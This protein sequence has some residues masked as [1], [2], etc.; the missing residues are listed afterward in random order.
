M[1]KNHYTI[2]IC[3]NVLSLLDL[4]KNKILTQELESLQEDKIINKNLFYKEFNQFLKQNHIRIPLFGWNIC[5]IKNAL[6]DDFMLEK[7]CEILSDY[8]RR[9]NY[10]N[11]EDILNLDK[12]TSFLNITERYI[13]YYY[14]KKNKVNVLR[15]HFQIFNNNIFKTVYHILNNIYTP[16]KI[17]VFGSYSE[18]PK[19]VENINR[20][21]NINATFPEFPE[22]YV[23]E[24]YKK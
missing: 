2:Y 13:D 23:L 10:Q 12:E 21:L 5:F 14:M 18:I 1:H 3:D 9:I 19:I 16:K 24:K 15:I 22:K 7:Y 20:K 4:K 6:M 11:I 17:V 8:C